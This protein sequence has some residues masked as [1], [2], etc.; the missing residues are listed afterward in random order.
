[1]SRRLLRLLGGALEDLRLSPLTTIAIVAFCILDAGAA[2]FLLR[3]AMRPIGLQAAPQA[4]WRLPTLAPDAPKKEMSAKADV[5]TLTRPIFFKSRRP[6]VNARAEAAQVA[7]PPV[8]SAQLTVSAIAKAGR[9]ERAF[10]LS[11]AATEGRWLAV[12]E[13]ID[14]WTLAEVHTSE[15]V[16]RSGDSLVRLNLYPQELRSEHVSKHRRRAG[17]VLS[18]GP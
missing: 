18:G 5:Q 8:E 12:G 17:H 16:L 7:E 3:A 15:V 1:M 2:L 6:P 13:E 9:A 4:A 14:G 11:S 10:L